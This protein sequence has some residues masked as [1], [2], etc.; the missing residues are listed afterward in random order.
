M[1]TPKYIQIENALRSEIESGRFESGISFTA[2]PS[3]SIGSVR[4]PSL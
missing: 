3:L 2:T 4:A 1:G